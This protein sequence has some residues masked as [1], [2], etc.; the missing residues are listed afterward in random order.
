[1]RYLRLLVGERAVQ[2]NEYNGLK[3]FHNFQLVVLFIT[4]AGYFRLQC[5][6]DTVS[7]LPFFTVVELLP[8]NQYKIHV[9]RVRSYIFNVCQLLS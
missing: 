6:F 9:C 5:L 4:F 8:Y 2:T 3:Y 1:M 7:G